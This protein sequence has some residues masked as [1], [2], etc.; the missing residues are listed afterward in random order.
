MLTLRILL[1]ILFGLSLV[2]VI[3]RTTVRFVH[4]H[5]IR[6]MPHFLAS[7][8]DNPWRHRIQPPEEMAARHGLHP[9]MTVLDIGP[10]NGT[11]TLASA[12]RVGP[13]GKVIALD[14]QPQMIDRVRR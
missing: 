9:G 13:G 3:V 14:I 6:P 4:R 10:G 12:R 8:I 11:Y 5:W 1:G 2:L 7:A